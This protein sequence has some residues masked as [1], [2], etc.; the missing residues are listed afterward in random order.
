MRVARVTILAGELA[1]PVRI[2][3]PFEGHTF[4]IATVQ[5]RLHRKHKVFRLLRRFPPRFRRRGGCCEAGDA[6]Q[7]RLRAFWGYRDS[8]SHRTRFTVLV[9]VLGPGRRGAILRR[10]TRN[11]AA[12]VHGRGRALDHLHWAYNFRA[13]RKETY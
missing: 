5:D 10:L 1:S 8:I 11:T 9:S 12:V 7:P 13:L 2:D 3:G 4:R 6:N